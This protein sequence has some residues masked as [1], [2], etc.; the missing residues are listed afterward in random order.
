MQEHEQ[1]RMKAKNKDQPQ[2]NADESPPN[3]ELLYRSRAMNADV[4]SASS[5]AAL[6]VAE[7]Y[8]A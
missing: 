4:Q 1:P 5:A 6:A 7:R 3:S 2:M 8:P